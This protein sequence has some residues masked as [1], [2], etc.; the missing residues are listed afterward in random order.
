METNTT[1][2]EPVIKSQ[3]SVVIT[4]RN[5]INIDYQIHTHDS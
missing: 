3:E 4:N 1:G 5:S 2:D